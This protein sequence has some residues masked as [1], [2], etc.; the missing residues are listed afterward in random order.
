MSA[1]RIGML[2]RHVH[3]GS[4]GALQHGIEGHQVPLRDL[5]PAR[6]GARQPPAHLRENV[7]RLL[8]RLAIGALHHSLEAAELRS[9]TP[10]GLR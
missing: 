7:A 4:P 5:A 2:D 9:R 8:S 6:G 10:N 1:Q 3:R